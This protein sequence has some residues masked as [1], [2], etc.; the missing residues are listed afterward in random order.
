[1]VLLT[2]SFA[3]R[4]D[5]YYFRNL[6]STTAGCVE[7]CETL[8]TNQCR[9]RAKSEAGACTDGINNDGFGYDGD[10]PID[11]DDSDCWDDPACIDPT[12]TSAPSWSALSPTLPPNASSNTL[13]PDS[14]SPS[15]TTPRDSLAPNP[16]LSDTLT[17]TTFEAGQRDTAASSLVSS[18]PPLVWG[19]QSLVLS[20]ILVALQLLV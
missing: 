8:S 19:G 7:N 3:E 5:Q 9:K 1:M 18:A 10:G 16:I 17:P 11:C 2:D 12:G 15:S 13:Q 6:D 14:V 20:L 4:A